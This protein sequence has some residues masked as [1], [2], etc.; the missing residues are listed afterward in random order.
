MSNDLYEQLSD[1]NIPA[2]S[3]SPAAQF[4]GEGAANLMASFME[5]DADATAIFAV[6]PAMASRTFPQSTRNGMR[7]CGQT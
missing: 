5:P 7:A 3:G 4:S 6:M 2:P 1:E